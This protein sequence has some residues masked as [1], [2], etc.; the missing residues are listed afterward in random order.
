MLENIL[1]FLEKNDKAIGLLH[2]FLQYLYLF[3]V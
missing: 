2:A 1:L 3:M